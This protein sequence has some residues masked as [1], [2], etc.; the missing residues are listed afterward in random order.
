MIKFDETSVILGRLAMV[1]L[2]LENQATIAINKTDSNGMSNLHHA[3]INGNL[4]VLS[5]LVKVFRELEFS[6]DPKTPDGLTPL[7]L[8]V[9]LEHFQCANLLLVEGAANFSTRDPIYNRNTRSW[10]D[11]KMQKYNKKVKSEPKS[12]CISSYWFDVW[13]GHAFIA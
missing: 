1:K 10:I 12:E 8:A 6:I 11:L 4:E 13:K 2:L 9:K 5:L 7:N 3:V